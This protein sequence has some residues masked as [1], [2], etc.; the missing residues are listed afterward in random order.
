MLDG[1]G[2][3]GFKRTDFLPILS[4][5]DSQ[6]SNDHVIEEVKPIILLAGYHM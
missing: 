3:S 4:S 6:W 5:C 2:V 1:T